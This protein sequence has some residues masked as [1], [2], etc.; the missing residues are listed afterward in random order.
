MGN[1]EDNTL[2][3]VLGESGSCTGF[4]GN[5]MIGNLTTAHYDVGKNLNGRFAKGHPSYN[6]T[7]PDLSEY[8]YKV[9]I[10]TDTLKLDTLLYL[11]ADKNTG[12]DMFNVSTIIKLRSIGTEYLSAAEKVNTEDFDDSILFS[13]TFNRNKMIEL[14]CNYNNRMPSD[15]ELLALDKTNELND[16]L[17]D[18][19]H[20]IARVVNAIILGVDN[21]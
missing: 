16:I 8:S 19:D 13:D 12:M 7:W 1:I 18:K 9:A 17:L 20:P 11:F 4:V 15:I 6:H 5:W 21:Y 10:I 2:L 14:Y 3:Y